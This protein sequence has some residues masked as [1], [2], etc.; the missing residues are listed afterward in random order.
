M[1]F[2]HLQLRNWRNFK[3]VDV[4]L[5][6]RVFIV[7]PNASGKSNL[8]DVFR[9]LRDVASVGGGLREAVDR[10]GGV[11]KIRCLA[12]TRYSDVAVEVKIG[13]VGDGTEWTYR[14]VF[15][16]DT[17]KRAIVKR[18]EVLRDE[19]EV[20]HRP[21]EEDEADPERLTQTHLE[22]V[23]ANKDFREIAG[24]LAAVK[25]MHIVPQLVRDRE[26]YVGSPGDPY[27]GDFLDEVFSKNQ[28]TRESRIN[29]ILGALKVAVP[30]LSELVSEMDERG[31]PHIK[32]RYE[33]WRPYGAWQAEDQFSDGTL[34]LFGLLW[35]VLDGTGPLLLEE[36]ELSLH[37]EVVRHIPQMMG[38]LA[39][40]TGRQLIVSTH[41]SD[42]LT[43]RGIAPDEVLLLMPGR[44]GT[45]VE[46]AQ[47]DGQIVALLDGGLSMADAALP[48]TAPESASQ[49]AMFGE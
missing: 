30:Q 1:R 31:V 32:G 3:S 46:L 4:K 27:G 42:F 16:Q 38:R 5:Q 9:F 25:Y 49:L 34:R 11:S 33:H 47:D 21:N 29:K 35:A 15:N 43:D 10:R 26:R 17:R 45:Q 39:R 24:F 44:G 2:L 23:T 14:L 41:S 8:L 36:P 20:L 22:Q 28:R 6:G 12:A 13:G 18:E 19:C 48:K 7:G 40:R 37:P